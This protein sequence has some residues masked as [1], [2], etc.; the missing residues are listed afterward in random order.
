MAWKVKS[1]KNSDDRQALEATTP[2]NTKT[3]S[4]LKDPGLRP[5]NFGLFFLLFGD[6]AHGF[7]GSLINNL[8]QINQWQ[9]GTSKPTP[10]G[11]FDIL[12]IVRL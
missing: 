6:V 7:D 1:L 5:L 10:S 2:V 11:Y 9:E 4:W 8:Q 3:V 12:M